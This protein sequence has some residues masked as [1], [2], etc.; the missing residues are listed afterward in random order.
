MSSNAGITDLRWVS[1]QFTDLAGFLRHVVVRVKP[2]SNSLGEL[3]SKL[4]GSSV[5]GFTGV[6][7][8]DL[9]LKPDIKTFARLPWSEGFGRLI[10]GVYLDNDRF[11]RDPRYVAEKL[12][13]V[14]ASTN[15]SPL[16]SAELEFFLFDKVFVEVS[17]Q[18]QLFEIFSSEASWVG[19]SFTNRVK[20]GYYVTYP[21]DKFTDLRTELAETLISYFGLEVEALHHEVAAASQHEISFRGGSLTYVSDSIQTIKYVARVLASL[22]GYTAVFMPKPIYGDNGNGMHVHVSLWRGNENMFYDP[23]DEYACLSQEARYF[24]GGLIE[25]GRAL[26][27]IV[28]P[29]TNSYRRL[30]PGY[31]APTYLAWGAG[32]RSVAVRIPAYEKCSKF[33]RVEYRPPDPSANPYLATTAIILAGLDGMKKKLEPGDPVKENLYEVT[34][35]HSGIKS[36]PKSL[37]E[38]LNELESDNEW[39]NQVFPKELL[40]TYIDM[41][42][43]ESRTL[44]TYP[45]PAEFHYYIDL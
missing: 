30:V 42:R 22:K 2:G 33:V 36:L 34:A 31:E 40:E 38:A 39:L 11:A 20:E 44:Q 1:L 26:S 43:R 23:D 45:N 3:I 18:K 19:Q 5:K 12:D 4:D 29:T 27:A 35:K 17:P 32:N 41:K 21:K 9:L 16:V 6:E 14:L 13:Y 24:I 28:S 8:S 15:L 10:C 7:E 37:D 25:H